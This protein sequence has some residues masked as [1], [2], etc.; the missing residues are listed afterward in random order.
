MLF[1]AYF[2]RPTLKVLLFSIKAA[3]LLSRQEV[4]S[5]A[6]SLALSSTDKSLVKPGS[7]LRSAGFSLSEARKRKKF[8]GLTLDFA[9]F[10]KKTVEFHIG[11][12]L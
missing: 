5:L 4:V 12:G 3:D 10:H 6:P 11:I 9:C 2:P 7:L 8:G 1:P